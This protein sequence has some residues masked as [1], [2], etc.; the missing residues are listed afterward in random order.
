MDKNAFANEDELVSAWLRHWSGH[1]EERSIEAFNEVYFTSVANDANASWRLI[2]KLVEGAR[3]DHELGM[4]G[5]GPLEDFLSTH[6]DAWIAA[7][8]DE[9]RHDPKFRFALSGTWQAVL[10]DER[11]RWVREATAGA[12]DHLLD[13]VEP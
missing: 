1:E 2:R 11:W 13:R 7:V 5:A 10:P 9:A 4:I 6:A 12:G 3:T 8:E